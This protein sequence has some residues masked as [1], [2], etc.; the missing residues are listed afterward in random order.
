MTI[1]SIRAALQALD[2]ENAAINAIQQMLLSLTS[3]E[4][5]DAELSLSTLMEDIAPSVLYSEEVLREPS[6]IYRILR[7]YPFVCRLAYNS[8]PPSGRVA[9]GPIDG[10]EPAVMI[11]SLA[12]FILSS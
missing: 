3:V 6:T 9:F 7:D 4:P 5:H 1:P 12:V 8:H 2:T 11:K 10:K